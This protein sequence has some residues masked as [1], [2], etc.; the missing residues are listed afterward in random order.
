[1]PT[2]KVH[3][4]VDGHVH[5][6]PFMAARTMLDAASAN[7]L[8]S[9]DVLHDQ[10]ASRPPG[11]VLLVADP[12][13]T[14]GFAR[15][16]AFR[17]DRPDRPWSQEHADSANLVFRRSDGAQVA[18]VRGQ[19]LV[20]QEG[21]EVLTF[22]AAVPWAQLPL[23]TTVD[24]IAAAGGIA[25]IPWGAGKWLGRR[26][27]LV[28]QLVRASAQR[29]D[30]LLADNGVR[31]WCWSRVPQF[32]AAAETGVRL[33]AGTDPW[34]IRGE[35]LRAGSYGFRV[36]L[37]CRPEGFAMALLRELRNPAGFF[38]L[39]GRRMSLRRFASNQVRLTLQQRQSRQR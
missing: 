25:I 17:D 7:F 21:L 11:G 38:P 28:T 18:A 2:E 4:L 6:Y 10:P 12:E 31:P 19:Q 32:E 20:T 9:H 36:S 37:N 34:P 33:I 22:G 29:P 35:E 1:M 27:R 15:L 23:F 30:I 24:R 8:R 14:K 13:G 3:L 16:A 5:L 39:F 26:G